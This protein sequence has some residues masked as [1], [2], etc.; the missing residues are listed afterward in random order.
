MGTSSAPLVIYDGD[1]AL[2]AW[3]VRFI[4]ARSQP[5]AFRFAARDSDAALPAFVAY[6]DARRIDGVL[7]VDGAQ[8][9]ARSDAALRIMHHLRRP[10]PLLGGLRLVPRPLRD[11]LYAIVA[12][13]RYRWFGRLTGG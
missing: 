10:W 5:G 1:C 9:F 2:C 3:S 4:T 11:A 6:P 12:R 8:L 7:L 13:Y